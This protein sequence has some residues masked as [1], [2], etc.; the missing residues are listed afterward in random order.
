MPICSP[1]AIA[2]VE[3]AVSPEEIRG[4]SVLEVGA[5]DVNG[6]VRPMLEAFEPETYLGVDIAPG[7]RVDEVAD[8][9]ELADRYGDESFDVVVATEVVEHVHDWRGAFTNMKRVLRPGGVLVVTT[10]SPGFAVHGYP[11]DFWRYEP[12]DMQTILSDFEDAEVTPDPDD[13]G[14]FAKAV[15][16]PDWSPA[17]LDGIALHSVIAHRRVADVNTTSVLLFKARYGPYWALRAMT[18]KRWRAPLKRFAATL[19]NGR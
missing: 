11:Y 8:V 17:P 4:R 14:V 3:D 2:F 9:V 18:P 7:P 19:R 16:P 6:S 10:R 1:S 15:K 5:L 13:P 12:W